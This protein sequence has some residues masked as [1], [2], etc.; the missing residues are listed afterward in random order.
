MWVR[1]HRWLGAELSPKGFQDDARIL[2]PLG[3]SGIIPIRGKG[4]NPEESF[5]IPG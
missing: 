3:G 2:N 1:T 5:G 4:L